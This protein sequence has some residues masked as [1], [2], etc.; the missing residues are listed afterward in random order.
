MALEASS[1]GLDQYRLDGVK[2]A[3]AGYHQPGPRSSRLSPHG[4]SLPRGQAQAVLGS[5]FAGA[6]GRHQCGRRARQGCHRGGAGTRACSFYCRFRRGGAS[7]RQGKRR[8]ASL[9]SFISSTAAGAM[10]SGFRCSAPTRPPTRWSQPGSRFQPGGRGPD[11]QR[12][13]SISLG[14]KGRLEIVGE[15]DGGLLVVDYAH[16]PE[17]LT[18]A[19][20]AVRPFASASSSA[21]SDAAAIAT[22]ASGRSWAPSRLRKPI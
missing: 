18:A 19:L 21:C 5:A 8:M 11:A 14:V 17:A 22:G 12:R 7:A 10:R 2:L 3:A 4:R 15:K 6:A 9:R 20:R 16:K 1:H 13:S